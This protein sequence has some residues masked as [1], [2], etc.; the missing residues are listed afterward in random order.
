M[1]YYKN[2]DDISTGDLLLLEIDPDVAR[3]SWCLKLELPKLSKREIFIPLWIEGDEIVFLSKAVLINHRFD[4]ESNV[5]EK[6]E[7]KKWI[8]KNLG[9]NFFLLSKKEAMRLPKEILSC[10]K[11]WWLRSP[12][13]NDNSWTDN[14]N[15][16]GDIND[17][18]AN[19]TV[20]GV[21]AACKIK[22]PGRK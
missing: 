1:K 18:Y 15:N 22:L 20:G 19:S 17:N 21:R 7:I 4:S 12:N 13:S 11:F 3:E 10:N 5:Y 14:V 8:M 2:V 16:S 9:R 6:S